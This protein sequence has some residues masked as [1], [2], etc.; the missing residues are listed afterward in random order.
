M[1]WTG[2]GAFHQ[3]LFK[4]EPL[5][6]HNIQIRT[7]EIGTP[8]G[9]LFIDIGEVTPNCTPEGANGHVRARLYGETDFEDGSH[10][11]LLLRDFR[12][13]PT[14]YKSPN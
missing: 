9:Q 2:V 11:M 6:L 10:D 1:N 3:A 12:R 4:Q 14:N 8:Q 5:E 13:N 7:E